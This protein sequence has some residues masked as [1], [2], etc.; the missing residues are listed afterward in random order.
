ML[1]YFKN[2]PSPDAKW[3]GNRAINYV[4]AGF[5]TGHNYLVPG[6]K[7]FLKYRFKQKGIIKLFSDESLIRDVLFIPEQSHIC[8]GIIFCFNE[9]GIK[10]FFTYHMLYLFLI[11]INTKIVSSRKKFYR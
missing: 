6:V 7:F 1:I 10:E 2:F 3:I 8:I 11:L 5:Y 4:F 9:F